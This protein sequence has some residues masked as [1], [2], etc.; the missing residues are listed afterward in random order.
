MK[1]LGMLVYTDL[2]VGCP[3]CTVACKQENDLPVGVNWLQVKEVGPYQTGDTLR[4][5]FL[6]GRCVHCGNPPCIPACSVNAISKRADGIVIIDQEKCIGCKKCIEACPFN[7]PQYDHQTKKCNMC[8]LCYHR[9]E[10]GLPTACELACPARV[11]YVGEVN[12]MI[13]KIQ[14]RRIERQALKASPAAKI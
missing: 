10:K 9:I 14:Q 5:D 1:Q 13:S 3:C 8:N 6:L 2:C 7:A 11:I 12:E 4:A